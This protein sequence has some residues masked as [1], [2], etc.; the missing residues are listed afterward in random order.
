MVKMLYG[1]DQNGSGGGV[2]YA[3]LG[4]ATANGTVTLSD[5][6]S[7]Y[8]F[9]MIATYFS[10]EYCTLDTLPVAMFEAPAMPIH[11]RLDTSGTYRQVQVA[12]ASDTSITI[13]NR[14]SL[15]VDLYGIKIS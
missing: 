6:L 1:R 11:I 15:N 12:Y 14:S 8:Q 5:S 2:S 9:V 4:R 13:S 3:R 10:S 7:N